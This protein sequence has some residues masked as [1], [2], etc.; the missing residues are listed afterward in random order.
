MD[1]ISPK[2]L[3]GTI[4]AGR[5]HAV[6]LKVDGTMV[7]VGANAYGQCDVGDWHSI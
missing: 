1:Y 5:R 7:T 6:G 3:K 2:I 4:A